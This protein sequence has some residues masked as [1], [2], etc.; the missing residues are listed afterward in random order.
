MEYREKI[1]NII[2]QNKRYAGN[3][4]LLDVFCDEILKRTES[5]ISLLKDEEKILS[6]I[7]RVS[8]SILIKV[9]KENGRLNR[10][11]SRPEPVSFKEIQ[12]PSYPV[13]AVF[14]PEF[15]QQPE[16]PSIIV[17]EAEASIIEDEPVHIEEQVDEEIFDSLD[18]FNNQQSADSDEILENIAADLHVLN[19]QEPQKQYYLLYKL[20][21]IDNMKNKEIAAQLNLSQTEVNRRFL[22]LSDKLKKYYAS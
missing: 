22:E 11:F 1:K 17:R 5:T 21:Y 14:Q 6:Y 7:S 19:S 3:E 9:L 12:T 13:E 18:S 4:D 10:V 20:R 16:E 8:N 15:E 2:E